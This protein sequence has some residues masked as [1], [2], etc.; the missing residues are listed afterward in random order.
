ML[1]VV[2][3]CR[4]GQPGD[5]AVPQPS[6]CLV[7]R[8]AGARLELVVACSHL[9]CANP[10]RAFVPKDASYSK[11]EQEVRCDPAGSISMEPC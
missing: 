3:F 11:C 10:L 1:V 8:G 4:E 9:C 5:R 2:G 6:C 7:R